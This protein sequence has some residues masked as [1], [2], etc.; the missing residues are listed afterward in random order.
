MFLEIIE[1]GEF[2]NT[3]AKQLFQIFQRRF[4]ER[5][6]VAFEILPKGKPQHGLR[7]YAKCLQDFDPQVGVA[8][9][10][11]P[12]LRKVMQCVRLIRRCIKT[13]NGFLHGQPQST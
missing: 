7:R 9:R 11:G 2:T 13:R 6:L 4:E 3:D 5:E 1:D 8:V 10:F 12:V